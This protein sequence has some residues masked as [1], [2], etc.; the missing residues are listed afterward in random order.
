M[1]LIWTDIPPFPCPQRKQSH[2]TPAPCEAIYRLALLKPSLSKWRS[3]SFCIHPPQ[4]PHKTQRAR[5]GQLK[6]DDNTIMA[7]TF[8]PALWRNE[9]DEYVMLQKNNFFL[10]QLPHDQWSC[11]RVADEETTLGIVCVDAKKRLRRSG[12]RHKMMTMMIRMIAM[13]LVYC[14]LYSGRANNPDAG[15]VRK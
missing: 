9:T 5:K 1:A 2:K 12:W 11:A 4:T 3:Q 15:G 7:H 10:N 14:L 13:N 8:L 6:T